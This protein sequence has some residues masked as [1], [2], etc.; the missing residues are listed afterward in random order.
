MQI[1]NQN[2]QAAIPFLRVIPIGFLVNAVFMAAANLL[3]ERGKGE[4]LLVM[5]IGAGLFVLLF[6][7]IVGWVLYL[8]GLLGLRNIASVTHRK[9]LNLW[10]L[11]ELI[12]PVFVL[13]RYIARSVITQEGLAND[14]TYLLLRVAYI[15]GSL[16]TVYA[17]YQLRHFLESKRGVRTLLI[18]QLLT[19]ILLVV[20]PILEYA[21]CEMSFVMNN[22]PDYIASVVIIV[23][24]VIIFQ[25]YKKNNSVN[26]A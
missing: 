5:F 18:G 22:V 24:W 21:N 16:F 12:I 9:M 10:L 4:E 6:F 7:A 3:Y 8:Y 11:A 26:E 23:G 13:I 1:I 15:V 14:L 2:K 25:Y 19:I 20:Y 17:M